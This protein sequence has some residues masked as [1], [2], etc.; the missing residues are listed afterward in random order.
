MLILPVF[1]FNQAAA[2]RQFLEPTAALQQLAVGLSACAVRQSGVILD[3][4]REA[5][6]AAAALKSVRAA[7]TVT[8]PVTA[9]S[10]DG[11]LRRRDPF[12]PPQG[13]PTLDIKV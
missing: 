1:G 3:I 2:V 7:E 13:K 11:S 9:A 6:L 8:M 12:C 10:Q 5:Y 4:S